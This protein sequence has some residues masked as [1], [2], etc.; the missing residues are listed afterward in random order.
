MSNHIL[1]LG[2]GGF[3]GQH[4]VRALAQHGERV[5]AVTR[6]P[7]DLDDDSIEQVVGTVDRPEHFL[8]LVKRS[9]VVVQLATASTPG[10][11]AGRPLAELDGNLRPT[12][13]L[14]E[15]M[16]AC[17]G[18]SL[19]YLSSGGSLYAVGPEGRAS[20]STRVDPRSYHGAGKIAAEHFIRAWSSQYDGAA[21][22]LRPSNL[23]GPGQLERRGFGIVPAGFGKIVRGETLSVWGNGSAVRDYLYIDDFI[24]LCVAVVGAPM[25][26]GVRTVNAS[27]G[28][29]ISLDELFVA[30]EAISGKSLHRSYDIG[31]VVDA[32][33]IVMDAG[34]AQRVYGWSAGT[35]LQEGLGRTWQW[36]SSQR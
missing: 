7:T 23:Y 20:E 3:V 15:A 18:T 8:P 25:S 30:M 6:R 36:F 27:S 11:S 4:L 22:L 35:S 16:Q 14:L 5:I 10:S 32:V 24:A 28:T 17:P 21:V 33:R 26:A 19:L 31:R 34:Y 12:L 2:A 9:R 13:A 29:G 1:V